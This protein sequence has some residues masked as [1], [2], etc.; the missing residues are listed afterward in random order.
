MNKDEALN[1]IAPSF[2][3][4]WNGQVWICIAF[5]AAGGIEDVE[6]LDE[7]PAPSF[8][9]GYEEL[10]IRYQIR[11]GFVNGGDSSLEDEG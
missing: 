10:G 8:F 1:P 3:P 9:E 2:A 4:D 7:P 5:N 6:L 11:C